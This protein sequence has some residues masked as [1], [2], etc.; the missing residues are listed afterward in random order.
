M[1]LRRAGGR[2][3]DSSYP[4]MPLLRHYAEQDRLADL[5]RALDTYLRRHPI[6]KRRLVDQMPSLLANHYFQVIGDGLRSGAD[7]R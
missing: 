7:S 4:L 1:A 3:H 5:A 6:D 2:P